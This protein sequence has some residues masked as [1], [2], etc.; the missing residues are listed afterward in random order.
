ML[1]QAD[2][3]PKQVLVAVDSYERDYNQFDITATLK[4]E[5]AP[6]TLQIVTDG[7]SP[8]YYSINGDSCE[9]A[10]LLMMNRPGRFSIEVRTIYG[11][12]VCRLVRQ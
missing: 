5:A 12:A 7:N 8:T 11:Y 3:D 10:L 6:K 1:A 2:A 4:G 9:R